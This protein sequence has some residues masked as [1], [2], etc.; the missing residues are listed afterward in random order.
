MD[1]LTLI[2]VGVGIAPMIAIIRHALYGGDKDA[3]S[4][5]YESG[6]G[7]VQAQVQESEK[8]SYTDLC[9]KRIK[10]A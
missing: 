3:G 4:C 9:K 1:H 6:Y 10:S 5:D 2:A 7:H 8:L